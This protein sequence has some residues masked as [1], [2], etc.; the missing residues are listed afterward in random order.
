MK[1]STQELARLRVVV[2][3][4]DTPAMRGTYQEAHASGKLKATNLWTSYRWYLYHV[5][6]D[7]GFRFDA[8]IYR[9][10]HIDTALRATVPELVKL[11]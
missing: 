10:A 4:I 5:A 7:D 9:D 1:V 6:Y 3:T 11:A 8:D 2:S